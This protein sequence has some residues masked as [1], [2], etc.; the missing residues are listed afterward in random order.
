MEGLTERER[1]VLAV[2]RSWLRSEPIAGYALP[3]WARRRDRLPATLEAGRLL[4]WK[5]WV[6]GRAEGA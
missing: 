5:A 4:E 2:Y 3:A 1:L 6:A